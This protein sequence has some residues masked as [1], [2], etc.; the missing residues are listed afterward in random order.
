MKVEK[1]LDRLYKRKK[2]GNLSHFAKRFMNAHDFVEGQDCS[3]DELIIAVASISNKEKRELTIVFLSQER[4]KQEEKKVTNTKVFRVGDIRKHTYKET[5]K[6]L[7]PDNQETGD[8]DSFR[9]VKVMAWHFWDYL[10]QPRKKVREVN[11]NGDTK[12]AWRYEKNSVENGGRIMEEDKYSNYTDNGDEE[13][14]F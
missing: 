1:V 8:A 5:L 11:Y 9:L 4:I 7:H 10:G 3:I 12:K 2:D 14:P 6:A 13:F